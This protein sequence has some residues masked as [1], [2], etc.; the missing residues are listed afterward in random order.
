MKFLK[1]ARRFGPFGVVAAGAAGSASAA[2]IDLSAGLT[3]I[4]ADVAAYATAVAPAIVTVSA[5]MIGIK[6][7]K[8]F[9]GKI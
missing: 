7:A 9:L 6:Y 2:A 5:V 1:Q 3:T 8:K 4:T